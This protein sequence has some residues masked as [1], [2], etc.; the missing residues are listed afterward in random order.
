MVGSAVDALGQVD[1][2]VNA[3][4]R[5]S[6]MGEPKLAEIVED[7]AWSD[8]NVKVLGY[9]RCA[10]AV[11]PYM[12][13]Q[14]W[15]SIISISGMAARR[16]GSILASARNAAVVAMTKSLADE[17]GPEGIIVT[18]VH[19]GTTRTERTASMIAERARREGV[20]LDEAERRMGAL[21]GINRIIDAREVAYVV[22]FLASPKAIAING[23]VVGV[24]GG[25]PGTVAY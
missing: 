16:G 2:L 19:P 11:A 7:Q 25:L 14:G 5:V 8:F 10:Q 3:A 20:S 1:I 6:G 15:G 4:A 13:R 21:S 24:A 9:L 17:L 23:E 12:R 18:A 22:A